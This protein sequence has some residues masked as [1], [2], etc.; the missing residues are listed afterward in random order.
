M[1]VVRVLEP[2]GT[3]I[4]DTGDSWE[5]RLSALAIKIYL[6]MKEQ[7]RIVSGGILPEHK[8]VFA[9][10]DSYGWLQVYCPLAIMKLS[11][12]EISEGRG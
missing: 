12:E 9:Y 1:T 3:V 5:F 7:G 8:G 2:S 6:E 10:L 11:L 4:Y